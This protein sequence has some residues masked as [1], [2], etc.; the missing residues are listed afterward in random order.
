MVPQNENF[1]SHEITWNSEKAGRIWSFY[2]QSISH[3]RRYFGRQTGT[4]VA[5]LLKR[6][7]LRKVTSIID[8]SCG[9]GDLIHACSK[10]LRPDQRIHGADVS[11]DSVR[12]AQN[13]NR[14]HLTF[15]G[16]T[17]INNF[18]STLASDSFDLVI[19]TEV[20]EHLSDPE[21][22]KVISE[23]KRIL[24]PSGFLFVTTPFEEDLETEKTLCPECGCIFHRWQHMRSWS[25][26]ELKQKMECN[27]FKTV[28]CR[29]IQWGP[30]LLKWYFKLTGRK[31]NGIYY[32]GQK[33]HHFV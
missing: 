9:R 10:F 26:V 23:I 27:G 32:F 19:A 22:D 15:S 16:I 3:Q 30:T 5:Q 33:L 1:A 17:A 25:I 7:V 28:E 13:L 4:E 31:G 11:P 29:N 12:A 14:E 2:S 21:L 6:K 18:P 8:F 20:I 24:R